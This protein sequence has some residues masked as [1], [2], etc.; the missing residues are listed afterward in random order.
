[1][2]LSACRGRS[3]PVVILLSL[4]AGANAFQESDVTGFLQT[5]ISVDEQ[6]APLEAAEEQGTPAP[7]TVVEVNTL[8]SSDTTAL[9]TA[10]GSHAALPVASEDATAGR[11]WLEDR[12]YLRFAVVA[13]FV[14]LCV[15]IGM[16][17]S[18]TGSGR[19]AAESKKTVKK[20]R[21][22]L[23][24]DSKTGYFWKPFKVDDTGR[25]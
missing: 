4:A 24:G 3:L 20:E 17:V 15:V 1:M 6:K 23:V 21:F 22:Y 25:L 5:A 8:N 18:I 11:G 12:F 19:E 14:L 16:V 9:L 13:E 10:P 2:E 7:R